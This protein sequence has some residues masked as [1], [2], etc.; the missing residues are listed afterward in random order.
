MTPLHRQWL[1]DPVL[2]VGLDSQ[3]RGRRGEGRAAP[4]LGFPMVGREQLSVHGGQDR[5]EDQGCASVSGQDAG[6]VRSQGVEVNVDGRR[7]SHIVDERYVRVSGLS[8]DGDLTLTFAVPE[9]V[10]HHVIGGSR[11]QLVLRG[12]NVVSIVTNS[13]RRLETR[14]V[15][16]G[17]QVRATLYLTPNPPHTS[18][19]FLRFPLPAEN[20]HTRLAE[21]SRGKLR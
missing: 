8:P 12:S 5:A 11:Y 13:L 10:E 2:R 20:P 9:R 7:L 17:R 1:Q 15:P 18:S 3:T 14:A 19:R 4:E 21:D 6:V 16:M